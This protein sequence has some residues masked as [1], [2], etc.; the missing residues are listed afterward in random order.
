MNT[1]FKH[2][3]LI[4]K[5]NIFFLLSEEIYLNLYTS[6]L[7]QN[8]ALHVHKNIDLSDLNVFEFV[9]FI[10]RSWDIVTGRLF[11]NVHAE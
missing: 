2:Y 8:Y 10:L 7:M 6:L 1:K 11:S 3:F 9:G 5:K 4:F